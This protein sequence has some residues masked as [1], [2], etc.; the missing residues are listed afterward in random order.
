MCLW[1]HNSKSSCILRVRRV[2]CLTRKTAAV[3][4]HFALRA[5]LALQLWQ[6][7][8]L[9]CSVKYSIYERVHCE[10]I[11]IPNIQQCRN[12]QQTQH[13][14]QRRITMVHKEVALDMRG[15]RDNHWN[16]NLHPYEEFV[17]STTLVHSCWLVY[18]GEYIGYMLLSITFNLCNK[19]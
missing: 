8:S 3:S 5:D 12:V 1:C 16:N 10:H 18:L 15:L 2:Q 13:V 6:N 4:Q 17:H 11:F 7:G 9:N 14:C 19:L